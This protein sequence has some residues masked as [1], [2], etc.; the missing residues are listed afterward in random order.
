MISWIY[1][2]LNE[3]NTIIYI[4]SSQNKY[5]SIRFAQHR[6]PSEQKKP[7]RL[8]TYVQSNG[9]WDRYEFKILEE[10]DTLSKQEL[11]IKEKNYIETHMP[12]CN[13]YSPVQSKEELLQY[14]RIVQTQ[15]RNK[16]PEKV[17]DK[18]NKYRNKVNETQEPSSSQ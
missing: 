6:S 18:N 14:H 10:C 2:I 13:H 11:R 9:G 7:T 8:Q 15:W 12:L 17:R 3:D 1:A 4:G 5:I 16:Y